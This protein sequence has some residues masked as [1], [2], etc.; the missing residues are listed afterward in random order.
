MA[1]ISLLRKNWVSCVWMK[2]LQQPTKPC[3]C[4]KTSKEDRRKK[5]ITFTSRY[6]HHRRSLPHNPDKL[7]LTK[8]QKGT[9]GGTL[10]FPVQFFPLG[11]I[12]GTDLSP[13]PT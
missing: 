1:G 4:S 5:P 9:G 7:R 13:S 8:A 2:L 11:L 12:S 10:P 3:S 6:I